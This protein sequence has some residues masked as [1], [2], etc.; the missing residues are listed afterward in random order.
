M[1]MKAKHMISTIAVLNM[2]LFTANRG[3]T[4]MLLN[5]APRLRTEI[6]I[7]I[8]YISKQLVKWDVSSF[9]S[10]LMMV[11]CHFILITHIVDDVWICHFFHANSNQ[12]G[13]CKDGAENRAQLR[14]GTH[15][16]GTQRNQPVGKRWKRKAMGR[17]STVFLGFQK[18]SQYLS[19]VQVVNI[20]QYIFMH[21]YILLNFSS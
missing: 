2:R 14:F 11:F 15:R 17:V 21:T 1:L 19:V 3:G 13:S 18:R 5:L 20:C 9:W 7:I 4:S 8:S 6:N 12:S 16:W 10:L